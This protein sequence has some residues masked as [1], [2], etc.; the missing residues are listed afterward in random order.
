MVPV[1]PADSE[2]L[3]MSWNVKHV[4][5]V[6]PFRLRS[7]PKIFTAVTDALQYIL[8]KQ[9]IV[10]ILLYLDDFLLQGRPIKADCEKGL[11]IAMEISMYCRLGVPIAVHKMKG[12]TQVLTF[13]GIEMDSERMEVRLSEDKLHRIQEEIKLWTRRKS[14]N[15]RNLLAL[16]GQLQH[17]CCIVRLGWTSLRLNKGFQSD[18]QWWAQFLVSWNGVGIMQQRKVPT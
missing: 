8:Q 1:H 3:G 5:T 13:L 6:L 10:D 14:T 9:R 17:A 15:K 2:M 16:I 18:L 7:A 4:D 12:P 11:H